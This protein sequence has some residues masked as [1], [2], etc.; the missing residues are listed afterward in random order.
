MHA[1]RRK[2][3]AQIQGGDHSPTG[4]RYERGGDRNQPPT[5]CSLCVNT[6]QAGAQNA[7]NG[8]Q[9]GNDRHH[10]RLPPES[11]PPFISPFIRERTE[12]IGNECGN[13]RSHL[14]IP[15]SVRFQRQSSLCL[16]RLLLPCGG[17]PWQARR[18]L[19][20]EVFRL[21][22]GVTVCLMPVA[23][24]LSVGARSELSPGHRRRPVDI[25]RRHQLRLPSGVRPTVR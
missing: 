10:N 8:A 23:F 12:E 2:G 18:L 25:F 11:S 20:G 13:I 19:R 17:A 3:G 1:W 16:L 14:T 4:E 24:V 15:A 7:H 21:H 9:I 22:F 6:R 5:R